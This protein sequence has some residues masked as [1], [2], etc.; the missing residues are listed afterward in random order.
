MK[1]FVG[2]HFDYVLPQEG[3]KCLTYRKRCYIRARFVHVSGKC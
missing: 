2:F 3:E 1:L